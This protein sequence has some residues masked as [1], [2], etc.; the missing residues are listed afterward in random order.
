HLA[1]LVAY[2]YLGIGRKRAGWL[3]VAPILF[4]VGMN[5]RGGILSA[6]ISI[7]LLLLIRPCRRRLAILATSF[8]ITIACF[9]AFDVH[10]QLP[11]TPR[12]VSTRAVIEGLSSVYSDTGNEAYD[13]T[14]R[15]RLKWWRKVWDYTWN[16]ELFWTGKG[17]GVNLA[18]DDGFV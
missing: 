4:V 14:K 5:T 13:A 16:G 7:G 2:L 11:W 3:L 9:T 17:F 15:W 10:L 6:C 1:G 8:V 18:D 12:E